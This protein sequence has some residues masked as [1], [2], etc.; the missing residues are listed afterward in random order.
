[1]TRS[2]YT[3]RV[4]HD[5]K[6]RISLHTSGRAA[7]SRM[8][9][10]CVRELGYDDPEAQKTRWILERGAAIAQLRDLCGRFGDNEWPD[11]LHLADVIEKHLGRYLSER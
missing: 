6:R 11:N 8:L 2:L 3:R 10:E 5:R 7:W 1:M 9:Q 4:A